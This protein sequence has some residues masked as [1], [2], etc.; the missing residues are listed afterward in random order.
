[1]VSC[2]TYVEIR[3]E[4]IK[5]EV[6]LLGGTPHLA[7]VQVGNDPAS[8][9]YIRNKNKECEYVGI[10][11]THIN[12]PSDVNKRDIA[13]TLL[14]LSTDDGVHGII[15][16]LPL[17]EHLNADELMQYIAPTK[18]VDGFRR[19]SRF[20]PCTPKGII[21]WLEHNNYKFEGKDICVIG[22]S[23]IVGKPLVNMLIDRGATVTCC[24]SKTIGM[25]LHTSRSDLV[26]S[27]IGK[28]KY[29]D[30]RDISNHTIVVDVGINRDENGKLCGDVDRSNIM[31]R[32]ED[33]YI[34]PV[35]GGVGKL[36][37]CGLL[38]NVI[39]AYRGHRYDH[40]D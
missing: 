26:I 16:Q 28:P 21:N 9:V 3:R 31:S 10:K 11:V 24:N 40:R 33:V 37:V 4:Q 39:E 36:T 27:A 35:P 14:N 17:P 13:R 6:A 38:E 19:S 29:F 30:H 8:D 7:V 15:L 18:D 32:R 2:K 25:Y 12:L 20:D 1:M 5:D 34:T 22:R 23:K